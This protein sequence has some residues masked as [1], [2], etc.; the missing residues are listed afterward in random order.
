MVKGD[1]GGQHHRGIALSKRYGAARID[2]LEDRIGDLDHVLAG[3]RG[4]DYSVLVQC[5]G[6]G[7]VDDVDLGIADELFVI[8]VRPLGADLRRDVTG[9][10]RIASRTRDQARSGRSADCGREVVYGDMTEP[11]DT[12]RTMLRVFKTLYRFWS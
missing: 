6:R 10:D 3:A 12:P 9:L 11:N 2:S 8:A 7:D 5:I 1:Q 4:R